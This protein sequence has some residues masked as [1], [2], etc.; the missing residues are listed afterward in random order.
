M[1]KNKIYEMLTKNEH[2]L[3][4]VKE[5]E[6]M[7]V[8]VVFVKDL[9]FQ[10]KDACKA[11]LGLLKH[12]YKEGMSGYG[13]ETNK[14]FPV[15]KPMTKDKPNNFENEYEEP[16]I[17]RKI[18]PVQKSEAI[19]APNTKIDITPR[20][21]QIVKRWQFPADPQTRPS[22]WPYN[23]AQRM[24]MDPHNRGKKGYPQMVMAGKD[25]EDLFPGK[26][27]KIKHSTVSGDG[28]GGIQF[29]NLPHNKDGSMGVGGGLTTKGFAGWSKS[30]AGKEFDLP[31]DSGK[32]VP[33]IKVYN[34]EVK[35]DLIDKL[36]MEKP[37]PV[38]SPNPTF[39]S[40][41]RNPDGRRG[42]GSRLGNK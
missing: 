33:K 9:G 12:A 14:D 18:F 7:D 27:T 21:P 10:P 23:D 32:K 38:G 8:L 26:N 3:E 42:F 16:N 24:A 13:I 5:M 20:D 19:G 40:G 6:P 2:A 41:G 17:Y 30:P 22:D 28:G 29:K 34:F 39:N 4:L 37:A 35:D 15:S 36:N 1:F 25:K 11:T 31:Q